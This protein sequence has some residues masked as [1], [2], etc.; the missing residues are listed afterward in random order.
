MTS[1]AFQFTC[2]SRST[3]YECECDYLMTYVS[4]HVP[5]AEHDPRHQDTAR[6]HDPFQFTCPSRSTTSDRITVEVLS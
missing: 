3:T 2:P 1:F 5:L 6:L 4:I